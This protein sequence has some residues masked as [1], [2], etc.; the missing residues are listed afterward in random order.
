[1]GK[2]TQAAYAKKTGL[3]RQ[4]VN[5]KV[6]AGQILLDKRG[7][8]DEQAAIKREKQFLHPRKGQRSPTRKPQPTDKEADG[9]TYAEILRFKEYF[10]GQREKLA[11]RK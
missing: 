5:Q 2:M 9:K 1:M 11:Y 4:A 3:T 10:K 6:K 8:I 7:L